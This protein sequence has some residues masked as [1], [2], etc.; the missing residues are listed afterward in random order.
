MTTTVVRR[1]DLSRVVIGGA[2]L[3]IVL[4]MLLTAPEPPGPDDT[5]RWATIAVGLASCT[6]NV[7]RAAA[8]FRRAGPVSLVGFLHL[9]VLFAF[10]FPAVEM[11]YRY[12]QI[13]LGFWRAPTDDPVLFQAA[14]LL[15]AFQVL[16]FLALGDGVDATLTRLV[17][18]SR[19]RWPD[20]RVGLVFVVLLLPL[21]LARLLVLRGL[22]LS[23]VATSMVTRT[24]YFAQ[25]DSNVSP[26]IWALNTAFPVY[27]VALGC[28]AVK[29]L[30]PHPSTLGRRLFLGVLVACAAGVALSGGRA[31]L[32]FVAITVGF[33]MYVAGY[34]T[35]RQ[36]VPLVLPG[37]LLAGL[38][39]AVAQARHGE[40]NVLSQASDGTIVGNDYSS[41]DIT[42]ILGLGRFDAMVMILD[43]H[44]GSD[45]LRGTSYLGALSGGLDTTFLP[46]IAAGVDLPSP[47]V[48]GEVLGQ[49]VFGGPQV[50]ALPSAPG[51]AY[52]N[53]G[54]V[55]L[56][57]A[58]LVL[59]LLTR[60]LVA[61][62]GSLPGPQEFTLVLAVWTMARLLSDESALIASFV[63][64]NWPGMILVL[65][66][67]RRAA[68]APDRPLPLPVGRR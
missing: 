38:L 57:G 37:L 1:P 49:W 63:V 29:F 17:G 31:E 46:R 20:Q 21:V 28:L 52:L 34:R 23:G 2:V 15:T 24:D 36:F 48:S 11:T 65:L 58:A 5:W 4:L 56:L 67:A 26:I 10:S 66:V 54:V 47:T 19:V 64:R 6:W 8:A 12:G 13:S 42:Q 41:G 30:V 22:G 3:A 62:A 18:S 50:S 40:D 9:W 43:R 14:L 68:A 27:A 51:E 53:F 45:A 7:T 59:G 35:A 61:V 39:F 55:G 25:L 44:L 32:V 60:G 33:F 16:F